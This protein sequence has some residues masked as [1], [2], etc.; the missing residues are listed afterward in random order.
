MYEIILGRDKKDSD[1]YGTKGC[2]FI[3]KQ[4]VQMGQNF[5][6]GNEIFMDVSRAHAMLICGKRGG[7]KSY[8]MGSIC[9]GLFEL[10]EEVKKNLCFILMDTM[11]IYWSMKYSNEKQRE[12]CEKWGLQVKGLDVVIYVPGGFFN[13]MKNN[14]IPVDFP[15]YLKPNELTLEDWN[16]AFDLKPND[17]LSV[18]ISKA[19]N[20]LL[21]DN[22]NFDLSDVIVELEKDTKISND[23]KMLAINYFENAKG[24]GVFSKNG[25]RAKDIIQRGKTVIMDLSVYVSMPG[26]QRIKSLVL[27]LLSKRVFIER[28]LIRKLEEKKQLEK[29]TKISSDFEVK[30]DIPMTWI[31]VDEAHEFLPVDGMVPSSMPLITILREGRQPGVSLILATQQP[32]KIH[33]DAITQSDI[34]LSHRITA[35]LDLDS[36]D[37]IFLSYDNKGAKA[38][39]NTMPKTKGCAIIMDDKNERL[40][41]MQ[42]K[43]RITWHGG[44]DPNAIDEVKEEFNFD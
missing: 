42:V 8:T 35:A 37:K 13:E 5:S 15:F 4:Y 10:E 40:H 34:V 27:G 32:G 3:G 9:E 11:G 16:N 24:W 6:L 25:T 18:I 19:I 1:K 7:G 28:M 33:T 39:F 36:L 38:I 22:I 31:I 43:P 14:G 12:L 23:T 2:V 44:E 20:K 26:G 41:T 30:N 21:G 29:L 17:I